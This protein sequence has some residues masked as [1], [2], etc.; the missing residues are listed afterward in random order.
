M[1]LSTPIADAA[2]HGE[3]L[4]RLARPLDLTRDGV[5][6]LL[7]E[8]RASALRPVL[9]QLLQIDA[10]VRVCLEARQLVS[11]PEHS[12]VLLRLQTRDAEWL[13]LRRPMF[14]Q[15]RLRVVLWS[16][17]GIAEQ[18]RDRA[19]DFFDWISHIV[20]CPEIVPAHVIAGLL[21]SP[22]FPGILWRGAADPLPAIAAAFP[23]TTGARVMWSRRFDDLVTTLRRAAPGWLVWEH[24]PNTRAL[25]RLRYALR[26]AQRDD[27]RCIVL[28]PPASNLGFWPIDS[29]YDD[30][31]T[32][33][34]QLSDND[35]GLG[36]A[37]LAALTGLEPHVI[38]DLAYLRATRTVGELESVL[39][40]HED[41]GAVIARLAEERYPIRDVAALRAPPHALRGLFP[42]RKCTDLVHAASER[43]EQALTRWAA[44]PM[45]LDRPTPNAAWTTPGDELIIWSNRRRLPET[46]L[47]LV[48]PPLPE[49][50]LT[51]EGRLIPNNRPRSDEELDQIARHFLLLGHFDV[52]QAWAARGSVSEALRASLHRLTD[53]SAKTTSTT[54]VQLHLRYRDGALNPPSLHVDLPSDYRD[55]ER[56]RMDDAL[57]AQIWTAQFGE[58]HEPDVF[59]AAVCEAIAESQGPHASA[60]NQD[61]LFR[62]ALRNYEAILGPDHYSRG[63][64][65]AKLVAPLVALGR[66]TEAYEF[67]HSALVIFRDTVGEAHPTTHG[68][69]RHIGALLL[70]Q[71]KTEEAR[72]LVRDI[73]RESLRETSP[74]LT[75]GETLQFYG[76]IELTR[77][78]PR[79]ALQCFEQALQ[80]VNRHG[81]RLSQ[82]AA[83]C[84][85][86]I[87]L[88]WQSVGQAENALEHMRQ[89]RAILEHVHGPSSTEA[90]SIRGNLASLLIMT[91]RLYEAESLLRSALLAPGITDT[92]LLTLTAQLGHVVAETGRADEA[93]AILLKALATAPSTPLASPAARG[94]LTVNLAALYSRSGRLSEAAA[95]LHDYMKEPGADPDHAAF[96]AV[97]LA[98]YFAATGDYP[99]ALELAAQGL[100]HPNSP[101]VATQDIPRLH[102][103]MGQWKERMELAR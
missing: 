79:A 103:E 95:L 84:H 102:N 53:L 80:A 76:T 99:R 8:A 44:L 52:S 62:R 94:A 17:P 21:A 28:S 88:A 87:A 78:R 34:A 36:G 81:E 60:D 58:L 57:F 63:Y 91:G 9:L 50:S 30:W 46:P 31:G 71:G 47:A 24:V 2:P 19:P 90:V 38:D 97:S 96:A 72:T 65:M 25:Q 59:V 4:R 55:G 89:A 23:E 45:D 66:S 75:L 27:L 43:V 33:A 29:G 48:P 41:P 101:L 73:L 12:L 64:S 92:A 82:A 100:A 69:V 26:E 93:E 40:A 11:L 14:A 70:A 42:Q 74:T 1:V 6:I 67:A 35:D 68:I 5:L 22:A 7:D 15:R 18:V 61:Y 86:H 37:R 13:N 10:D 20:S 54:H 85:Q 51:L 16:E 32:A 56:R 98:R 77:G 3:W 39:R 83:V 49:A